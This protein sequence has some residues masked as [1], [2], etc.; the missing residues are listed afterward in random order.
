MCRCAICVEKN[1]TCKIADFQMIVNTNIWLCVF[2]GMFYN[3]LVFENQP[4]NSLIV[5]KKRKDK[6]AVQV[7]RRKLN[8]VL[9]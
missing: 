4:S 1:L 8:S 3:V 7:F 6:L 9:V 2:R 5:K